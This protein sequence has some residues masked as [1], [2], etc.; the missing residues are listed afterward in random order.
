MQG[1]SREA[2]ENLAIHVDALAPY[3]LYP[4]RERVAEMQAEIERLRAIVDKLPKTADGVT[5]VPDIDDV[6]ESPGEGM[7]K[8]TRL[9]VLFHGQ[10]HSGIRNNIHQLYSTREA[11]EAAGGE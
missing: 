9:S 8:A 3:A 2:S 10:F 7:N 4:D 5:V 1:G 6:W 11:A